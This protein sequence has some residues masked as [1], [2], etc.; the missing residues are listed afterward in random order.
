[1][2]KVASEKCTKLQVR[3]AQSCMYVLYII[4]VFAG[5]GNN[6]TA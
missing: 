1:M 5:Q 2:H 6:Q 4:A 3:N